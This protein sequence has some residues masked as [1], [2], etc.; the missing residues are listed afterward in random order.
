MRPRPEIPSP[1]LHAFRLF[2][3]FQTPTA[4][5]DGLLWFLHASEGAAGA[6][7]G[8]SKRDGMSLV[9]GSVVANHHQ[10]VTS[11]PHTSL[12]SRVSRKTVGIGREMQIIETPE[13]RET[14][15]TPGWGCHNR[16]SPRLMPLL[17]L[18]PSCAPASPLLAWRPQYAISDGMRRVKHLKHLK[19]AKHHGTLTR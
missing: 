2:R 11:V 18:S 3:L 4:V 14:L 15:E 12:S 9:R 10:A 19:H 1:E 7:L 17:W 13:T 16:P 5:G 6:Q 8:V